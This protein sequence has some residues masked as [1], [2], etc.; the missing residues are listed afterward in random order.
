VKLLNILIMLKKTNSRKTLFPLLLMGLVAFSSLFITGCKDDEGDGVGEPN[1]IPVITS[2]SPAS[3]E[4]GDPVTISGTDLGDATSVRFGSTEATITS[5]SATEIVTEVPEGATTGKISITT[6]G[7]TAVSGTDFEVITVGA[8][9]VTDVSTISAQEGET[10]VINGTEMATVTSVE[11]G[12]VEATVENVTETSVEVRIAEGTPLGLS[13][14]SLTNEGGTST[15][16][17]EALKFY[18]ID[19]LPAFSD[20]F[21]RDTSVLSSGGDAEINAWGV[22]NNLET[23]AGYTPSMLPNPVNANFYHIEGESDTNDSGSY[24]GQIGHSK[25]EAGHFAGFLEPGSDVEEYYFN[26]QIHWSGIPEGYD[27]YLGGFRLRFDE[28]Y[29]VDNDGSTSDEYLAFRPT[30]SALAEIGATPNEDGW[31]T[32]SIPFDMFT[33]AGPK[34]GASWADYDLDQMTRYAIASR[35]AHDGP[36]SMSIDNVFISRGGPYNFNNPE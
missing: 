8:P 33:D 19:L 5:N 18:V 25:Q 31:Y 21:D 22:N 13:T 6:A 14:I 4:A 15:T 12:G 2:F 3:G 35:R 32:L 36:Y 20:T 28:G 17:T 27:D 11:I 16:S 9:T 26:I 7:G 24:T 1:L 34:G 23:V 10:V 30:P 29:D